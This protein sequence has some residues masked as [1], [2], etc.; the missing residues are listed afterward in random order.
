ML[1]LRLADELRTQG[2]RSDLTLLPFDPDPVHRGEQQLAFRLLDVIADSER[3]ICIGLLAAVIRHPDKRIW[4]VDDAL[5][6]DETGWEPH[7]REATKIYVAT[8][9]GESLA[10]RAGMVPGL[11]PV[12]EEADSWADVVAA[13][14]T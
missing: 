13:L 6:D 14:A 10:K 2:L 9:P 12:P 5:V 7:L 8:G 1:G 4:I 11:L 3:L